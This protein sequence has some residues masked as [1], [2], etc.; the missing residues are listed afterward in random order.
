MKHFKIQYDPEKKK[1]EVFFNGKLQG[2]MIGKIAEDRFN[3]LEIEIKK[4]DKLNKIAFNGH[5]TKTSKV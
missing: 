3:A 5:K 2:G 4:L 1:L